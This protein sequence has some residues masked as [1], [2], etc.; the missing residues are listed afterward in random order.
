MFKYLFHSGKNSKW[1]YYLKNFLRVYLLPDCLYRMR[2]QALINSVNTRTDKEY[3]LRRVDYYC[4]LQSV[5]PLT[6]DKGEIGQF[7]RNCGYQSVYFFDSY[8]FVRYFPKHLRWAYRFGDV[9]TLQPVPSIVKSRPLGDDNQ[10]SVVL[11]LDKVRHFIFLNDKKRFGE[12]M[13]RAV[14]RGKIYE[15]PRR[16]DFCK[17][18]FGDPACD[19]GEIGGKHFV[20][21]E[22]LV[23]KMT[24]YDH[25]DFKFIICLEGND[26]ASNLK[27]VMNSNSL[28]VMPKPTC[29]T[30]FME[31]CLIPNY[32]YVEIKPDYSDLK[33][34]MEY[35]ATHTNEAEAIIA[36][37][38]E[39]CAQFF[40][41]KREQLISL[42][43]LNKYFKMTGQK[44]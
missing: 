38:H 8:E 27:W 24:L 2:L 10:N 21:A 5:T 17:R 16:I 1:K 41:K 34:R 9:T 44:I 20:C 13:N 25:L 7:N 19:I 4:R 15:K 18:W 28:A 26:V 43:V 37:A 12:K 30:W 32:H 42:L 11:N 6:Q 23:P 14:F 33:E 31:G 29:E 36:H 39:W 40:D 35:F 3:I 22:W